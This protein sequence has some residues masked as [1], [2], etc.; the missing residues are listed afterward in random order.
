M[1]LKDM[2]K[3]RV[4]VYDPLVGYF[5]AVSAT[6]L[7]DRTLRKHDEKQEAVE[8]KFRLCYEYIKKMSS[9]WQSMKNAVS[10]A[11]HLPSTANDE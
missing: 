10:I 1:L 2:D 3:S 6:V 7:L 5:V 8:Q 4:T 11:L 9:I